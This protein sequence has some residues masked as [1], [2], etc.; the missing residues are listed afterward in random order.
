MAKVGVGEVTFKYSPGVDSLAV[1]FQVQTRMPI[2]C[3]ILPSKHVTKRCNIRRRIGYFLD[4][5]VSK[6]LP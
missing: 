1:A 3:I 4:A 2:G 5:M 6:G